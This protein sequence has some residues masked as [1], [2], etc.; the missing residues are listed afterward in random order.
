MKFS[1]VCKVGALGAVLTVATSVG[2]AWSA[3]CY[4]ALV[5]EKYRCKYKYEPNIEFLNTCA[6]F[7]TLDAPKQKLLL[8]WSGVAYECTCTAKGSY[9]VPQYNQGKEFLCSSV[10]APFDD[11]F[12]GKVLGGGNKIKGQYYN[13]GSNAAAVVECVNDPTCP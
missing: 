11:A 1:L 2:S 3:N 13:G 12:T 4:D 6:R 5:G 9:A 10:T 8:L 7:S